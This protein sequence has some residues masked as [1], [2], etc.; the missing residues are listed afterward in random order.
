MGDY[1]RVLLEA[2]PGGRMNIS[3]VDDRGYGHGHRLA[4]RKFSEAAGNLKAAITAELDTEDVTEIRLYLRYADR[5]Q[6]PGWAEAVHELTAALDRWK[7]H[8]QG[9]VNH[10]R[11]REPEAR[12]RLRAALAAMVDHLGE[13]K[14]EGAPDE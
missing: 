14:P 12:E 10:H 2:Y 7:G 1:T 13:V 3:A 4:G 11:S 8:T 5:I 6:D 9:A